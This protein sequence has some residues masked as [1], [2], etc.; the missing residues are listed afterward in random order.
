MRYKWLFCLVVFFLLCGCSSTAELSGSSSHIKVAIEEFDWLFYE[1]K[2]FLAKNAP[3]SYASIVIIDINNDGIKEIVITAGYPP[4]AIPAS[5]VFSIVNGRLQS[6]GGFLGYL[7]AT[8][9]SNSNDENNN[10]V[11]LVHKDNAASILQWTHS[12]YSGI[13]CKALTIVDVTTLQYKPVVA[14][15]EPYMN[16]RRPQTSEYYQISRHENC[17]TDFLETTIYSQSFDDVE[18][19]TEEQFNE[20]V[21]EFQ[22]KADSISFEHVMDYN[23]SHMPDFDLTPEE[24]EEAL[25]LVDDPDAIKSTNSRIAELVYKAYTE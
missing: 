12:S 11:K 5:E 10:S 2:P 16:D 18:L 15:T 23:L 19:I 1:N 6:I 13:S 25:L 14:C 21:S 4:R 9:E 3:G 8:D 7:G 22:E 20:L 24:T 17:P